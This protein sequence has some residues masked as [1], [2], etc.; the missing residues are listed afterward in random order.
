MQSFPWRLVRRSSSALGL[1][2]LALSLP[3]IAVAGL[4]PAY[5]VNQAF[6][7]NESTAQPS[8]TPANSPYS[9]GYTTTPTDPTM[10]SN[11]SFVHT[12]AFS[13]TPGLA[14]FDVPNT[15]MVPAIIANVT[16]APL[17]TTNYGP[18]TLQSGELLLHPG[19]RSQSTTY[20]PSADADIKYT[21]GTAGNYEITG[22]FFQ[23]DQR[24]AT[25]DVYVNGVSQFEQV[26]TPNS[27]A[28]FDVLAS[29]GVG[30][31]VDFIVSP[32][33]GGDV[34]YNSTG[35]FANIAIATPEPAT[36]ISAGIALLLS[37]G[38]AWRTRQAQ[39]VV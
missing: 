3:T 27:P 24:G 15:G 39:P 20:D 22:A 11:S 1:G 37:S 38:Y 35:L 34:S 2:W 12:T 23:L 7:D 33:P 13:G 18:I 14:G 17:Q 9:Y 16:A 4:I 36:L 30:D 19:G 5:N 8:P 26:L 31:K 25:V 21:V 29:L 10:I 32:S 28:T 6:V